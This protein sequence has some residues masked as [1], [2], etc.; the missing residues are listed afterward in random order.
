MTR[1]RMVLVGNQ[2]AQSVL[3][4]LTKTELAELLY[5]YAVGCVGERAAIENPDDVLVDIA[6]RQVALTGGTWV[7]PS[8]ALA[9]YWGA[10]VRKVIDATKAAPANDGGAR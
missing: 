5:A 6:K 2:A 1:R 4:Q 8:R 7:K 10:H 9:P 3:D